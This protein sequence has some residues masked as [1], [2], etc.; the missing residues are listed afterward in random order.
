MTE[1]GKRPTALPCPF[2]GSDGWILNKRYGSLKRYGEY[3]PFVY[4][5]CDCCGARTKI[6]TYNGDKDY[7]IDYTDR[8]VIKAFAIWNM[9]TQTVRKVGE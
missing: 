1:K 4:L 3:L 5:E 6:F 9:R 2:C 8:G 7:D